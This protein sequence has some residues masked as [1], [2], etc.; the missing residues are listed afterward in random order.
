[1]GRKVLIVEDNP[2]NLYLAGYLLE[3]AGFE[4]VSAGDGLAGVE[5]A[6][7]EMPDIVLMD[8]LLPGIDGYEATRRLKAVAGLADVPVVALTAYSMEGDEAAALTVG[9]DGYISKPID[10]A[11][12]VEQVRRFLGEEPPEDQT[13]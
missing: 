13:A 3:T 9:C 2:Q 1:M 12:F 8:I 7:A 5:M 6:K 11:D 4:V 10:P